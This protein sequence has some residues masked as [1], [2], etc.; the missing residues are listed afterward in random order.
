MVPHGRQMA[1][2]LPISHLYSRENEE[3]KQQEESSGANIRK[4][5]LPKRLQQIAS[6]IWYFK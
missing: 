1:A 3:E 6:D 5:E 4:P 2:P